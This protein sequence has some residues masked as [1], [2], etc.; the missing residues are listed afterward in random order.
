M[1]K[2]WNLLYILKAE[3]IAMIQFN[4]LFQNTC[5]YL[6]D[7]LFARHSWCWAYPLLYMAWIALNLLYLYPLVRPTLEYASAVC[8]LYITKQT[9][10]LIISKTN[11]T[12]ACS[13]QSS[14]LS[15]TPATRRR[16]FIQITWGRGGVG[17]LGVAIQSLMLTFDRRWERFCLRSGYLRSFSRI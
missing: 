14:W 12:V 10:S 1:V 2:F 15:G 17:Y 16:H 9:V 7:M 4:C 13:G 3:R 11:R 8:D 5:G 6:L